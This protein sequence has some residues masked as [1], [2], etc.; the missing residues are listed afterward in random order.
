MVLN[1]AIVPRGHLD[2]VQPQGVCPVPQRLTRRRAGPGDLFEQVRSGTVEPD[3]PDSSVAG[4]AQDHLGT[5]VQGREGLPRMSRGQGPDAKASMRRSPRSPS[6]CG[7]SE[8]PCACI[9]GQ[10]AGGAPS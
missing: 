3:A 9:P 2:A 10:V 8:N 6:A 5:A 1:V 7:R 4:R